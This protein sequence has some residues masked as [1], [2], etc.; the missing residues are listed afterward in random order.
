MMGSVTHSFY[1]DFTLPRTTVNRAGTQVRYVANANLPV[2]GCDIT[3][4]FYWTEDFLNQ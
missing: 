3:T 2:V 1:P 4:G